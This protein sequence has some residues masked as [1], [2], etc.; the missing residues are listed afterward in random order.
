MILFSVDGHHLAFF[1]ITEHKIIVSFA[2]KRKAALRRLMQIC[3]AIYM[4]L[5]I[6]FPRSLR[7]LGI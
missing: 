4:A 5:H 6:F 7:S 2:I 3:L 1:F